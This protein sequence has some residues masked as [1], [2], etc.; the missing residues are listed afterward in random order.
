MSRKRK[1]E[2]LA[3]HAVPAVVSDLVSRSISAVIGK[4]QRERPDVDAEVERLDTLLTMVRAV[5]EAAEGVHI[6]SLSLRRWLWMLRDAAFEGAAVVR[7]FRQRAADEASR[8]RANSPWWE[9]EPLLRS[10]KGL[11]FQDD[12][13]WATLRREVARLEEIASGLGDFLKLLDMETRVPLPPPPPPQ[14]VAPANPENVLPAILD[15]AAGFH[16]VKNSS[17]VEEPLDQVVSWVHGVDARRERRRTPSS[18]RCGSRPLIRH[19]SWRQT[20]FAAVDKQASAGDQLE[21]LGTLLVMVVVHSAVEEADRVHIASWSLRRWLSRLRDAA[22]DG[23]EVLRL[24]TERCR[25]A[26]GT[27]GRNPSPWKAAKRV[28]LVLIVTGLAN[29]IRDGGGT[30]AD[31]VRLTLASLESICDFLREL[32][33]AQ[34]DAAAEAGLLLQRRGVVVID[35]KAHRRATRNPRRRLTRYRQAARPGDRHPE[36]RRRQSRPCA[37]RLV[38][39]VSPN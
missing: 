3:A 24:F 11:V 6:R 8:R 22:L 21:R 9:W 7:S 12:G 30:T 15:H 13:D 4:F 37:T 1:M 35:K 29:F 31:R 34:H 26:S 28:V 10:G 36:S 2:A 33:M 20:L 18:V 17:K 23:D 27:A 19:T 14:L 32:D 5:V 38:D 25:A 16:W 39:G